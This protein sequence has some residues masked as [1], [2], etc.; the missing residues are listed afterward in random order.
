[1]ATQNSTTNVGPSLAHAFTTSP[2][3]V[4]AHYNC[5]CGSCTAGPSTYT[6]PPYGGKL[7]FRNGSLPPCVP[8]IEDT[9]H[10]I[11]IIPPSGPYFLNDNVSFFSDDSPGEQERRGVLRSSVSR[12]RAIAY[13][14]KASL[15]NI[16]KAQRHSNGTASNNTRLPPMLRSGDIADR[17]ADEEARRGIQTAET[18][19]VGLKRRI[20]T[21]EKVR[22]W[23][24]TSETEPMDLKRGVS[25]KEK[26]KWWIQTSE[27][28]PI[29]LKRGMSTKEKV[30]RWIQTS[31]TEPMGL[32]RGMSKKEA[33]RWIKTSETEPMAW[34]RR[35]SAEEEAKGWFHNING[36][37]KV[38][39]LGRKMSVAKN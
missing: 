39:R 14:A 31:E 22:R 36:G 28:E 3:T 12:V 23:I 19:L 10:M 33:K 2:G 1:M 18:Q 16:R 38:R 29:G 27:T 9:R 7:P 32:K 20:S 37:D 15:D 35:M 21:K 13:R 34:R 26:V 4:A 6:G 25:T 30:K 5:P 17:F 11:S 24:Q 8:Y